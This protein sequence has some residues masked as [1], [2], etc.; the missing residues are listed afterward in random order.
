M[1]TWR[2]Q[3]PASIAALALLLMFYD[4]I[5]LRYLPNSSG[6]V[7]ADYSLWLPD[8]LVGFFWH[9]NNGWFTLPWFSPAQCG[10]VPFYADPEVPY[11][12]LPQFLT[13]VM[14]PVQALRVS[15][16]VFAAAGFAGSAYLAKVVFR[17]S[18]AASVLA[19]T[20]FMFNNFSAARLMIGHLTFETFLLT[21]VI[22]SAILADRKS[23]FP[24]LGWWW[25]GCI[26]GVV[27]AVMIQGGA[28]HVLPP[29]LLSVAI[30]AAM[31]AIRFGASRDVIAR[32]A[33]AIGI[34]CALSA[35][36]LA[37]SLALVQNFPRDQYPLPGISGPAMLLWRAVQ[38]LFIGPPEHPEAAA[39]HSMWAVQRHEWEYG[40][41]I[42]PLALMLLWLTRRLAR[43]PPPKQLGF[44]AVLVG[45]LAVPVALN[46]YQPNW[47]AFLKSLPLLGSSSTLLRWFAAYILPACL[48]GALALD[49]TVPCRFR[50]AIAALGVVFILASNALTDRR[51]YGP[52]GQAGYRVDAIQAAWHAAR[53]A[54][55]GPRI[56]AMRV[57]VDQHE[58]IVLIPNRDDGF[59][60]GYSQI[61]CYEP[62]FGYNLE[63]FPIGALRP[64]AALESHDGVLNVKNPA[65]YVFPGA[66]ACAPGDPFPQ[67]READA[68]A[69]LEYAPFPFKKPLWAQFADW[70]GVL[71]ACTLI[72]AAAA[73]CVCRRQTSTH[74]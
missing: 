41:S 67:A 21:P 47:N 40:V 25:P 55:T 38:T 7:G 62:L 4:W 32:F 70:L 19:G 31:H 35:G 17:L 27:I 16:L 29:A 51:F 3:A 52:Q 11:L 10:G 63:R 49:A 65:C 56:T 46:W 44:L 45:L 54:R 34:G 18:T 57:L 72:L 53:K 36:K 33:V 14:P 50:S 2:S 60:H 43:T 1:V 5:F 58:H 20:L 64:G 8:L 22:A 12:S 71:T 28:V 61:L 23:G 39:A 66:N 68:A 74:P 59:T 30:L 15:A 69:F 73:A 48:G 6:T 13:F 9:L 37:A 26:A 24:N 42:V